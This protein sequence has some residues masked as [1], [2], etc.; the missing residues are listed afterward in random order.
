MSKGTNLANTSTKYSKSLSNS[1]YS[2]SELSEKPLRVDG[3]EAIVCLFDLAS[4]T[5]KI[6]D[7]EAV[8]KVANDYLI[9]TSMIYVS[10]PKGGHGS[11]GK[12]SDWYDAT[13]WRNAAQSEGNIKDGSNIRTVHF[14]FGY[15][16]ANE[17]WGFDADFNYKGFKVKAE[18]VTNT[19]TY[20]FAD[21]LAGAGQVISFA[22]GL[23]PRTG[24][25]FSQTSNAYYVTAEKDWKKFGFA[26]EVF[27]MGKYYRPYMDF[28]ISNVGS[29]LGQQEALMRSNNTARVPV[30]EDNDD[31]DQYPDQ[32]LI[33]R[34]MGYMDSSDDPDGVFPGNDE[35]N[36][37]IPDTNKNINGL[38]DSDEPFLMFDSDPDEFV[39]GNDY[40]N[41]TIPDFREDDMKFDTPY[42]LDRQGHHFFMKYSPQ[43]SINF[44][45]GSMKSK[46]IGASSN[47]TNDDYFKFLVNYNVFNVGQIYAEYRYEKI[48]DNI[49]D[50]YIQVRRHLAQQQKSQPQKA[51]HRDLFYDELEYRNSNVHRLWLES[52]IR[53]LPSITLENHVKIEKNDQV[54]GIMYDRTFQPHDQLDTIA[55]INKFVYTKRWG[56]IIFSPGVKFR[57]YKKVRSESL[58]PLDHNLE[59]IPLITLKYVVSPKSNIMLGFQ[60]IPGFQYSY[61]NYVQS[62]N[63]FRR[64]TYVLQFQNTTDYFGYNVWAAV[65]IDFDQVDYKEKYREFEE[66]KSSGTFVKVYLG[67]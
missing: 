14:N 57:L 11:S 56:N 18:Y 34:V 31:D 66:Y 4:C 35:D 46:G 3:T 7:I 30:I 67:W 55:I 40:N 10:N 59:R 44:V 52:T 25:R 13:Y 21:G 17:I 47:R 12:N 24:H 37:G 41:N 43:Q 58:Q 28:F 5:E 53:A 51:F 60:G 19:H 32:M 29:S 64:I 61:S 42:E 50:Q 8:A 26:G 23:A 49:R 1:Y 2:V 16:V 54:E 38:P 65:G 36:D 39:F 63:D 62:Q 20:M 6:N 33:K 9:Q 22:S 15:E 45:V 27:K 48:Q